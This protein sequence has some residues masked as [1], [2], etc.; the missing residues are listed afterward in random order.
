MNYCS[1]KFYCYGFVKDFMYFY[2]TKIK[3]QK[4][5]YYGSTITFK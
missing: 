2:R 5:Q 1:T 4:N 3:K